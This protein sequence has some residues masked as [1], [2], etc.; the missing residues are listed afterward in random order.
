MGRIFRRRLAAAMGGV[1]ALH[2][3]VILSVQLVCRVLA[4]RWDG[5]GPC[6]ESS[7]TGIVPHTGNSGCLGGDFSQ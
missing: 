3:Y 1:E 7:F 5:A 6:E 2:H 4:E